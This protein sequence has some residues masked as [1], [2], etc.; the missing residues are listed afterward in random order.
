MSNT[1]NHKMNDED[2]ARYL[3][4]RQQARQQANPETSAGDDPLWAEGMEGLDQWAQATGGDYGG[5]KTTLD[6]QIDDLLPV[7]PGTGAK[8]RRFRPYKAIAALLIFGMLLIAGWFLP[9]RDP[10]RLFAQNFLPLSHPDMTVRG[11]ADS[12]PVYFAVKAYETENYKQAIA[13]YEHL[14]R[15]FPNEEKHRLFLGIAYLAN[16]QPEKAVGT[17]VA[18]FTTRTEFDND[19]KWYLAL[20]YIRINHFP[21]A[22]QLLQELAETDSFYREQSRKL[23]GKLD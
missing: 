5:L 23:A 2:L 16:Y 8:T 14:C 10:E 13:Y 22:K 3:H 12:T 1:R 15:Q 18:P 9:D 19:R 11:N 7:Q 6:H 21:E 17:L 20:A 4:D